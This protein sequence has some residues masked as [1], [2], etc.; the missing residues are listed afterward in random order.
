MA[1]THHTPHRNLH[2]T[3]S[4]HK[5]KSRRFKPGTRALKEIR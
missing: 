4:V 2:T 3:G 5:S 1:R